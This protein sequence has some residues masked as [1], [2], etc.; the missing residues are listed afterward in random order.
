M[1]ELV[2]VCDAVIDSAISKRNGN[3]TVVLRDKSQ[4]EK[5][6]VSVLGFKNQEELDEFRKNNFDNMMNILS[7]AKSITDSI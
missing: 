5:R 1:H 4:N 2:G 7:N 6:Y 3:T